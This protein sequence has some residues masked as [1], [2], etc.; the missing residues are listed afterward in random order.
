M[1]TIHTVLNINLFYV[2][3]NALV[4]VHRAE[5][6]AV[7][8]KDFQGQLADYNMVLPFLAFA[9]LFMIVLSHRLLALSSIPDCLL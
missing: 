6:L 9:D 5:T 8:I 2:F 1:C 7:E 4:F 3:M